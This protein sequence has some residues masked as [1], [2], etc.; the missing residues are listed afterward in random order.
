M[1]HK[2][3]RGVKKDQI[4]VHMVYEWPRMKMMKMIMVMVNIRD[5]RLSC[6]QSSYL[7]HF[8]AVWSSGNVLFKSNSS[9]TFP[10]HSI[11]FFIF[12]E[13]SYNYYC[14]H[15]VSYLTADLFWQDEL[16]KNLL[17]FFNLW[18]LKRNLIFIEHD[19]I[20]A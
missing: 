4:Y 3:G 17:S 7:G 16:T 1:V 13:K 14:V 20:S 8:T 18:K 10:S 6:E 11:P 2:G 19:Q 15:A 12:Q 5:R 9:D